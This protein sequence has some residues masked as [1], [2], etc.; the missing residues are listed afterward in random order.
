MLYLFI[1]LAGASASL[2]GTH[3]S[4]H[5]RARRLA[6]LAAGDEIGE[7]VT[8]TLD[9]IGPVLGLGFVEHSHHAVFRNTTREFCG[10]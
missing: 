5:H 8:S 2:W 6:A 3:R 1:L 4:P 10:P 7:H 9:F